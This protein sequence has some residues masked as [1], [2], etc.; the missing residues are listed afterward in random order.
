MTD[1]RAEGARVPVR[2]RRVV[3]RV[4]VPPTLLVP[5]SIL[6]LCLLFLS[7]APPVAAQFNQKWASFEAAPGALPSGASISD[8]DHETDLDWADLDLN[9]DTEVVTAT[10]QT[11]GLPKHLYHNRGGTVGGTDVTLVGERASASD[12]TWVG[13]D[14]LLPEDLRWTHDVA[15]FDVDADAMQDL[16]LSRRERTQVWRQVPPPVCQTDLGF[17]ADLVL[18]VCGGD[19]STGNDAELGLFAGEP[20][21]PV[22]LALAAIA[23]PT[24]LGELGVTVVPFPT[25]QV[26]TSTTTG[27]GD[28]TLPVAGGLGLA[29]LVIQAFQ[30]SETIVPLEA[31][32]AIQVQFL[33]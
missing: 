12:A 11:V 26:L 31:S 6:L 22:F 4:L 16:L 10:E 3:R 2:A 30:L 1:R 7:Q 20:A 33:P 5:K 21:A 24:P 9:G 25:S 23:N 18:E 32:K 14:G 13:A 8:D 15:V 28:L 27:T 17:G 29:T 19:P